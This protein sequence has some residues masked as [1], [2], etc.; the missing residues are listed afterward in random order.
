MVY[1]EKIGPNNTFDDPDFFGVLVDYGPESSPSFPR[2]TVF[3]NQRDIADFVFHHKEALRSRLNTSDLPDGKTYEGG[4]H[5]IDDIAAWVP[6]R[7]NLVGWTPSQNFNCNRKTVSPR[8]FGRAYTE[9]TYSVLEA[10]L[11]SSYTSHAAY[12]GRMAAYYT[13]L[14][15]MAMT[16]VLLPLSFAG[17]GLVAATATGVGIG[18]GAVDTGVNIYWASVEHNPDMKAQALAGAV[19]GAAGT[20]TDIGGLVVPRLNIRRFIFPK[21]GLKNGFVLHTAEEPIYIAPRTDPYSGHAQPPHPDAY[22][23]IGSPLRLGNH[24]PG[25]HSLLPKGSILLRASMAD[26][27]MCTTDHQK[28][29]IAHRH[30]LNILGLL[31]MVTSFSHLLMRARSN[32]TLRPFNRW[33]EAK[34]CLRSR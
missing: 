2:V 34:T 20:V 25:D 23:R 30:C 22:H 10:T 12:T 17:E 4:L 7:S 29:G 32:S 14:V 19:M 3:K 16:P 13:S 11:R 1:Y 24:L 27:C 8:E 28:N 18:F 5:A 33:H 26:I 9:Q 6:E 15:A 21:R 31:K